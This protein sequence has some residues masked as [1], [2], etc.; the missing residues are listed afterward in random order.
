MHIS[1]C[2]CVCN[3]QMKKTNN[4]YI[5]FL[6]YFLLVSDR[7]ERHNHQ[8]YYYYYLSLSTRKT[9]NKWDDTDKKNK[10]FLNKLLLFIWNSVYNNNNIKSC[11][12]FLNLWIIKFKLC[13]RSVQLLIIQMTQLDFCS[14]EADIK[15]IGRGMLVSTI[16]YF[17][18]SFAIEK[19][20]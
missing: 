11:S 14:H 18:S 1:N 2:Q 17:E 16:D 12:S 13:C 4:S 5:F 7:L 19:I 6:F 3:T 15:T 10:Q 20:K 8:H 9:Q